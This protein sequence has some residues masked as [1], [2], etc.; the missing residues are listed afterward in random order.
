M[1]LRIMSKQ[2]LIGWPLQ[3]EIELVGQILLIL[4]EILRCYPT[5]IGETYFS[6]H[7]AAPV[8][9]SIPRTRPATHKVGAPQ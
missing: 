7:Q 4:S 8:S 3:M 9:V 2:S 5:R 1:S 6:L